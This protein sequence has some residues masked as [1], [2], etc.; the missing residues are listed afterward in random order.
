M[1]KMTGMLMARPV[2][3]KAVDGRNLV[4]LFGIV[5]VPKEI[6]LKEG[7]QYVLAGDKNGVIQID[8]DSPIDNSEIAKGNSPAGLL[9]EPIWRV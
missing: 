8:F 3:A 9:L 7:H 6:L 2:E 5:A 4:I 1:E